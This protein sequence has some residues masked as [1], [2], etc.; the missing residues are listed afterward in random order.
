[1][2]SKKCIGEQ[3]VGNCK[4]TGVGGDKDETGEEGDDMH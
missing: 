2:N 3:K 1:M 4:G